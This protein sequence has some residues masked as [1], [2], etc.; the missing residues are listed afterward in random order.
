MSTEW[1]L[2]E[3]DCEMWQ[4]EL[5]AALETITSSPESWLVDLLDAQPNDEPAHPADVEADGQTRPHL[6]TGLGA[7]TKKIKFDD[8]VPSDHE[9]GVSDDPGDDRDGCRN[10]F[11][12]G[13]PSI[14]KTRLDSTVSVRENTEMTGA[15][16]VTPPIVPVERGRPARP[17]R[18]PDEPFLVE[19]MAVTSFSRRLI[20]QY[21][22]RKA[23]EFA[24][25]V[26]LTDRNLSGLDLVRYERRLYDLW[27][28][29]LKHMRRDENVGDE[30][31]VRFHFNHPSLTSGDI[32]VNLQRFADM[33][34][35]TISR[36]L[37]EVAQSKEG[38]RLDDNLEIMMGVIQFPRGGRRLTA[39]NVAKSRCAGEVSRD[40]PNHCLAM[41]LCLCRERKK[42]DAGVINKQAFHDYKCKKTKRLEQEARW[43]YLQVKDG[44][45]QPTTFRDLATFERILE[46]NIIVV[47]S[48]DDNAVVWPSKGIKDQRPIYAIYM[49]HSYSVDVT[50]HFHAIFDLPAALGHD[51][52]CNACL[53]AH[54][55]RSYHDCLYFCV[56]CKT[57]KCRET[58][59]PEV[60]CD[61][62]GIDFNNRVC[63]QEHV[64][65]QCL[66]YV[67][68]R[69]CHKTME[70]R[71]PHV[72]HGRVCFTCSKT[73]TKGDNHLCY[74][75]AVLPKKV[76]KKFV[77]FDFETRT[78]ECKHH[79]VNY[80]VAQKVCEK[81][82]DRP[83]EDDGPCDCGRRCESCD[84]VSSNKWKQNY[85]KPPC[86]RTC[87]DRTFHF[88]GDDVIDQFCIWLFAP[89][90]KDTIAV[91][92][93][94]KAYDGVFVYDYLLK[95]G[96]DVEVII[97]GSKFMRI[98]VKDYRITFLDSCNFLPM[99]LKE[100][101]KTFDLQVKK[102]Y[103]PYLFNTLENKRYVGP[104]LDLTYFDPDGLSVDE[105]TELVRWHEERTLSG[106]DY[107]MEKEIA[108]YC[109]D[110]VRLMKE[111]CLRFRAMILENTKFG[112]V[113]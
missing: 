28:R 15:A 5:N 54:S 66:K 93:N 77:F 51:F 79:V 89:Q 110:D 46:A 70:R 86:E 57:A 20:R 27:S 97:N 52:F 111:G 26:D 98:H 36:R 31:L 48:E 103:F 22:G 13:V 105:R 75:R 29:L 73:V 24:Y 68:C 18:R 35:E 30:D 21:N 82:I 91:A 49:M 106:E 3:E 92:H 96:Y 10:N 109:Q 62:C 108:L 84:K 74:V 55:V 99:R 6:S 59:R 14:K 9:I 69:S 47:A 104:L 78:D 42:L 60:R 107:A 34:S 12:D 50:H 2:T 61:D 40:S 39:D 76:R 41:A 16:P 45:H 113:G 8:A 4:V 23:R 100:F 87:G 53:T 101:S 56:R 43:L 85:V 33:T 71:K 58:F 25:R 112:T 80:A 83:S 94:M 7:A 81:C 32:K 65:T 11:G 88:S 64:K 95:N 1:G 37:S 38:L 72:C 19:Q 67:K 63:F 44:L 102:G 90:N 17:P